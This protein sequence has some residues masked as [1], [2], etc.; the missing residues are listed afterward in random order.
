MG[1][2]QDKRVVVIGAVIVDASLASHLAD[3]GRNINLVETEGIA[4]GVTWSSL[5]WINTNT[6]SLTLLQNCVEQQSRMCLVQRW[7]C[8]SR[9]VEI[10]PREAERL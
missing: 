7:C 8:T 9:I 1:N 3:Q 2:A 6:D 10:G 4:S 5:A